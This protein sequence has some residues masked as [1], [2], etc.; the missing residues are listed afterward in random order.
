[1]EEKKKII[2]SG[3]RQNRIIIRRWKHKK[4]TS[5]QRIQKKK[6]LNKKKKIL[7]RVNKGPEWSHSDKNKMSRKKL[8]WEEARNQVGPKWH[9][10]A[11]KMKT[12]QYFVTF[13]TCRSKLFPRQRILIWIYT[14]YIQQTLQLATEKYISEQSL[15]CLI[16]KRSWKRYCTKLMWCWKTS[17]R[18]CGEQINTS[19]NNAPT[20]VNNCPTRCDY[21]Q[22]IVFLQTALLLQVSGGNSTHLQEHI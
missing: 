12:G 22:L 21:V 8:L 14:N 10:S 13:W 6:E 2:Q 15:V 9:E 20:T 3:C 18:S 5:T 1:M 19:L 7:Q 11:C 16:T 4:I 17:N